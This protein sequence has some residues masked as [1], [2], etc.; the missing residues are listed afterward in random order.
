VQIL[1]LRVAVRKVYNAVCIVMQSV[2]PT[3]PS[4]GHFEGF[5]PA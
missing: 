4:E 2:P 1:H 5:C 3:A